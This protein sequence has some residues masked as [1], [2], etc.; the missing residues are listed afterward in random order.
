MTLA[1]SLIQD[2]CADGPATGAG[3]DSGPG[4]DC[5]III[6][7]IG[8]GREAMGH[9]LRHP[10]RNNLPELRSILFGFEAQ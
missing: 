2:G 1:E 8:G 4:P 5:R 6:R 10:T 7:R 3:F 9:N